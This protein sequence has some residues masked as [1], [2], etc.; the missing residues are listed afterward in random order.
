MFPSRK[1][2]VGRWR[3]NP[4]QSSHTNTLPHSQSQYANNFSKNLIWWY[5]FLY[6]LYCPIFPFYRP[7]ISLRTSYSDG[8]RRFRSRS[9]TQFFPSFN[10]QSLKNWLNRNVAWN[11]PPST[12]ITTSKYQSKASVRSI[13]TSLRRCP[14]TRH[15]TFS[16]ERQTK[17]ANGMK[18]TYYEGESGELAW[19]FWAKALGNCRWR[20]KKG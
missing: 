13:R 17:S 12:R 3:N 9:S 2:S 8:R 10:H 18:I 19:S 16:S 11:T 15:S 5:A 7:F 14:R 20:R 4:P 6:I 1:N